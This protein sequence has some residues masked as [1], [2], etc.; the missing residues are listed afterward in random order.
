MSSTETW[1]ALLVF[2]ALALMISFGIILVTHLIG[3]RTKGGAKK[4]YPYE[5]G[6]NV[7]MDS[8]LRFPIRFYITAML[9]VIFDVE[10]VFLYPW[11][12]VYKEFLSFGNFI[13]IE[14]VVFIMILLV[15]YLY[16]WKKGA[17]EWE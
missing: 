3:P 12:V 9:F 8:R 7:Y 16:A 1:F 10:I 14:M 17:F 6:M 2:M 5:S 13:L 11:A 4:L 15:G